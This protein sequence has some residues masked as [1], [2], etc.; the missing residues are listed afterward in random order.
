MTL[1]TVQ[2]QLLQYI[3]PARIR[4]FRTLDLD[5]GRGNI[6]NHNN[7]IHLPCYGQCIVFT[8]LSHPTYVGCDHNHLLTTIELVNHFGVVSKH[9]STDSKINKKHGGTVGVLKICCCDSSV[10][11]SNEK[12]Y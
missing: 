5:N 2:H 12:L 7:G 10:N 3:P 4:H 11:Q 1:A 6:I 9:R 8:L